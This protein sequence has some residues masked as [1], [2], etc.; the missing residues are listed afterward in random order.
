M[1][2][3]KQGPARTWPQELRQ[4]CP[5]RVVGQDAQHLGHAVPEL[6]EEAQVLSTHCICAA[7]KA[8]TAM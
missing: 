8:V 5:A 1:H 7:H 6:R 2:G 3:L 4:R